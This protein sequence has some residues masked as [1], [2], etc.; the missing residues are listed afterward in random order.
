MSG[1]TNRVIMGIMMER[2]SPKTL[3][4][5]EKCEKHSIQGRT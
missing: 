1:S 3:A 2:A 5:E 4:K